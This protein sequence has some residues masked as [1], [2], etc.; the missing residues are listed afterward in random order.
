GA[1]AA[2]RASGR[3]SGRPSRWL[4]LLLPGLRAARAG[5]ASGAAVLGTWTL[6]WGLLLLRGA[7]VAA[8]FRSGGVDDWVALATLALG[9]AACPIA[10]RRWLEAAPREDAGGSRAAGSGPVD[11]AA[12]AR[13]R[14]ASVGLVLLG[15]L[16]LI[17]LLTP[18]LAP[19]DPNAQHAVVATRFLPP[20]AAHPLGTDRF[21]RDVLSR[22]LYGARISLSIGFVAV[23]I[24]VSVG[25][26]V[27]A[28]AGMAGGLADTVSMRG[29]DLLLSFPRLVLL[30][31]LVALFEPSLA[32]VTLVLGATGWMG[33]ARIVRGQ[34]LSIR[35]EDY[36]QAARA[37]GFGRWRILTRHVLP[38]ALT[39]V[40]VAATLGV[41]NTILAE[42]A[43]SFLGLGVQPPTASWGNMVASG[44]D[45][46]LHAW[47]IAAFP[48]VAI[49]LTVVS[50]NLVGDGL[51]DALDPRHAAGLR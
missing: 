3:A 43:L 22:A 6:L 37:L 7:R 25:T 47:W 38:N 46:M 8:T 15:A 44:R 33:T 13:H 2:G 40:I 35:E 17:A 24:A 42:A 27:G 18:Y 32:L 11:W 49:V 12:F 16:L 51:R 30:I 26:L 1:G 28:G 20:S 31:A 4:D 41:G 34:V 23:A 19:Y 29:V 9:L 48:G 21:G 14:Q 5:R 10:A 45:V 39:P 50:F 36:V